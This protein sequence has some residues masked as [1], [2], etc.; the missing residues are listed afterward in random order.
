MVFARTQDVERKPLLG[1][2]STDGS[3]SVMIGKK[4]DGAMELSRFAP[5]SPV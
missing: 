3:N 5:G 4:R 2:G 1:G